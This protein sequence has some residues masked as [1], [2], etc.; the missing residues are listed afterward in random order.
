MKALINNRKYQC[1]ALK[2]MICLLIC[3]FAKTKSKAIPP[4]YKPNFSIASNR[5][6]LVQS[7]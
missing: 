5:S 3:T 4:L 1:S 2:N 6:T 7:I